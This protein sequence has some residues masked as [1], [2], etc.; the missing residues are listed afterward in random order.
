MQVIGSK[1]TNQNENIVKHR[2]KKAPYTKI[3]R[4]ERRDEVYRL[5][6]DN[7]MPATRIAE[8]MKVDRNTIN[9]DLKILYNKAIRDY[10][11]DLSFDDVIEK[12]LV[13]LETQ[14]DR[15]SLY[16]CD[17]ND[18]NGKL[19]IERLIADIDLKVIGVIE[20]LNQNIVQHYNTVIEHV[21]KIAEEEKLKTRFTSLFELY[22]IS[23]DSRQDLDK[24]KEKV[25]DKQQEDIQRNL[26][27]NSNLMSE[28]NSPN[29]LTTAD[30]NR[31]FLC[32]C[33]RGYLFYLQSTKSSLITKLVDDHSLPLITFTNIDEEIRKAESILKT[34]CKDKGM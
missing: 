29:G 7:G 24:L 15:L 20:K 26:N 12:Q 22:R 11:S 32:N 21:N 19:T 4:K 2:Q 5:H 8:L 10:N 14:R 28:L 25:W 27:R 33:L 3:Q 9:N 31:K 17:T 16:L 34:S 13:R 6:F 30:N 1:I 18:I 23:I